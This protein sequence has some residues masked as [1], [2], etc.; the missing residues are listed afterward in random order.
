[1]VDCLFFVFVL[2]AF[3]SQDVTRTVNLGGTPTENE[4]QCFNRYYKGIS[5]LRQS[6][7]QRTTGLMPGT[8]AKMW[9][10][11]M[12]LDYRNGTGHGTTMRSTNDV[13]QYSEIEMYLGVGACLNV[14]R[15]R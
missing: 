15:G 13:M 10:W 6:C 5:Q 7:F 8:L 14:S 2:R 12:G 4:K 3:V 9:V 1:M 11:F